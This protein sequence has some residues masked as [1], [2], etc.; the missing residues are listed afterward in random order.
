MREFT[1]TRI[2]MPRS[3]R[4]LGVMTYGDKHFGYTLEDE[5][6]A[7]GE[8]VKTKT[9]IP[10]GRYRLITSFSNRFRREM[11]QVLNVSGGNIQFGNRSV[12]VCGIRIHGGNTEADSEG[13]PL[14]G[15]MQDAAI[16]K[17]WNCAGVNEELMRIVK[18]EQA[19]GVVYLNIINQMPIA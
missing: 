19:K 11:I 18:T 13:C 16:G 12:D 9:A 1:I 7:E 14:L 4:T 10:Q 5:V 2:V 17:I 8:Y 6:R 3:P 15:K